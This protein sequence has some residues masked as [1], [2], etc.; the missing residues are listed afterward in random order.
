MVP[1]HPLL[2]QEGR[3]PIPPTSQQPY[4]PTLSHS[5]AQ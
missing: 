5:L 4:L 3:D 1:L 2:E